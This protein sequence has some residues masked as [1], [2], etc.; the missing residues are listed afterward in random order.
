MPWQESTILMDRKPLPE[1]AEKREVVEN[2]VAFDHVTFRYE[3]AEKDALHEISLEIGEGEHVAFVGPV[4][5][6]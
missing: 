2:S 6:R 1:T 3:N 4:R 5:R